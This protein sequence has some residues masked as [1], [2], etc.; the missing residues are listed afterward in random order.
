MLIPTIKPSS[1]KR[2]LRQV[3]YEAL[4]DGQLKGNNATK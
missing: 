3:S 4:N 1:M 2:K